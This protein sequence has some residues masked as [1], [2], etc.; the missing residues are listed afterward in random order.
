MEPVVS[1]GHYL[2]VN[3]ALFRRVTIQLFTGE[4]CPGGDIIYGGQYSL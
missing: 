4:K 2:L 3:N 1:G